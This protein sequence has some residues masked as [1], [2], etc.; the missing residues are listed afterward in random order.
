MNNKNLVFDFLL[1]SF[2]IFFVHNFSKKLKKK[3]WN[4]KKQKKLLKS[5]N[6]MDLGFLRIVENSMNGTSILLDSYLF[7]I[8]PFSSTHEN[9]NTFLWNSLYRIFYFTMEKKK[10]EYFEKQQLLK[11]LPKIN[12]NG[13][14]K[15]KKSKKFFI[16]STSFSTKTK[17]FGNSWF[18]VYNFIIKLK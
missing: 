6:K 8:I 17:Y 4:S 11:G 10:E 12:N 3:I 18:M 2:W 7:C 14:T 1:S 5:L 15:R 13:K 9:P 16:K